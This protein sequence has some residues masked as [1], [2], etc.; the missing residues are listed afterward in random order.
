MKVFVVVVVV[1]VMALAGASCS[2]DSSSTAS[3]V[4]VV[5]TDDSCT[6]TRTEYD[7]GKVTFNVKNK[8]HKVTEMY[9][10]GDDDKVVGEVENIGPGTSRKMTV[11]VKAGKYE[12]ACKP[13]QTGSGI[14]KAITVSGAGGQSNAEKGKA[15]R[16]VDIKSTE[17]TFTGMENFTA[18][19]G[20]TIEFKLENVGQEKHEFE[21]FGPDGKAIGEVEPVEPGKTGEAYIEFKTAG[22]HTY[23]CDVA[24]H[25]SKGMTGAFMVEA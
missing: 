6:P 9:V 22:R 14:R 21:V 2:S 17:Y 19:A 13:G 12:L 11:D 15:S 16:Q 8:G 3:A 24:D 1:A 7:A 5:A 18:K 4:D 23:I 20:E 10:Y 25:Q